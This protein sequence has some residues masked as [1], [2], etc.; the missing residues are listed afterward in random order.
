MMST[1][2]IH[3]RW[4]DETARERTGHLPTLLSYAK[5]MKMK[6]LTLHTYGCLRASSRDSSSSSSS[7]SSLLYTDIHI[8]CVYTVVHLA[9]LIMKLYLHISGL[10]FLL[11]F[12][13][14]SV[15]LFLSVCNF[16]SLSLF[17]PN[18]S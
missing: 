18:S 13:P 1:P 8:I 17:D 9:L 6:S 2:T 10:I 4:E 7:S 14:L 5:A 11:S 3:C 15:T 12:V 16:V